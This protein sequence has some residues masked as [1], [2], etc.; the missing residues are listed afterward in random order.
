MLDGFVDEGIAVRGNLL[1][2][3][4]QN[5]IAELVES[6]EHFWHVGTI[7]L[8][9]SSQAVRYITGGRLSAEALCREVGRNSDKVDEKVVF[10]PDNVSFWRLIIS[11]LLQSFEWKHQGNA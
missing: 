5:V 7:R 1:E 9:E 6:C 4:V 8:V 10:L 2:A 3:M 11:P